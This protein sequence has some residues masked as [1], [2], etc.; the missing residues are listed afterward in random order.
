M[1]KPVA[2]LRKSKVPSKAKSKA[3]SNATSIGLSWQVQEAQIREL[4]SRHGDE[5]LLLL[6][7]WGRSGRGD[8]TRRRVEYLRLK[9]MVANDEVSAVY[10]YSLSRLARSLSEYHA[11]AELCQ[12][13][14]VPIRLCKE[15]EQ[16]YSTPSGRLIMSILAAVAQM[17]AE[18]AQERAKDTVALRRS[19]GDHIGQPPYGYKLVDGRLIE[20]PE[21][22][23][24]P[25]L[26]AYR[27]TG[28]YHAAAKRLNAMRVPS[29]RGQRWSDTTVRRIVAHA[30]PQDI[31]TSVRATRKGAKGGGQRQLLSGLLRCPCGTTLT[32]S[33][34]RVRD[35][36][37]YYSYI[38][39]RARHDPDHQARSKISERRLLPWIQAEA[40]RMH[41][42]HGALAPDEQDG[43][44]EAL[45]A[46]R[47][48]IILLFTKGTID[49][50]RM[51]AMIAEVDAGLDELQEA[52]EVVDIPPAID[53]EVWKPEDI[54]AVLR[55]M[56]R[57][58][59]LGD[60][61]MPVRAEWTVPEWR[62]EGT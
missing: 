35:Y 8:K 13:R 2:Y 1:R 38:C 54:N 59:E 55:A 26:A 19:R 27:E 17:E 50:A 47:E 39:W 62:A 40:Q 25:V 56:W 29:R 9:E 11:L 16:D 37:P 48:R 5:D 20:D 32:P 30:A 58:V 42:P 43:R 53:W 22:P 7:D 60:D 44:R 23:I 49:E 41:I 15:G 45:E 10:S 51:D 34:D 24:E 28:S 12:D 36:G 57:H 18:L 21:R 14:G 3:T 31:K 33:K 61:L 6:S 46:E 52:A 4:A